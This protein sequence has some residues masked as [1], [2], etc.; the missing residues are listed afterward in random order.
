MPAH[1]EEGDAYMT[2]KGDVQTIGGPEEEDSM[3]EPLVV[4]VFTDFV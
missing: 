1:P 4:E 2:N 3:A